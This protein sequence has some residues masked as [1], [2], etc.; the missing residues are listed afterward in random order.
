M[1]ESAKT[2]YL[3]SLPSAKRRRE[4][5]ANGG[6]F[7]EMI[8]REPDNADW[9]IRISIARIKQDGPFSEWPETHRLLAPLDAPMTLRFGDGREW[10]AARLQ[11][12]CFDGTPAPFGVLP[13]GPTRDFNL[14]L[15]NGVRGGLLAR[16]LVD[17][18]VLLREP[19]VR[20][21]VYVNRGH[22]T[23]SAGENSLTLTADD[24]AW[25]EFGGERSPTRAVIEGAGELVLAK[26]A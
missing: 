9:K 2:P 3:R 6:G 18:M 22:A 20:W 7:T 16:T 8:L 24:A 21:L 5:W 19:G 1:S 26:L 12:L 10:Q 4:P 13:E 15:R 11:V 17:S 23:A 14:M 25:I